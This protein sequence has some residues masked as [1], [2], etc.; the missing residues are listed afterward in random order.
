[1]SAKRNKSVSGKQG[2]VSKTKTGKTTTKKPAITTT[3][4]TDDNTKISFPRNE[5]N[6]FRVGS[7][8]GALFDIMATPDHLQHGIHKQKLIELLARQISK[9]IRLATFDC[10]VLCSASESLTGKRHRSCKDGFWVRKQNS[11]VQ[12]MLA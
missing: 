12:L 11:H 7:S 2:K 4:K 9:P 1:M 5:H 3:A 8:Y 6:P 10:N